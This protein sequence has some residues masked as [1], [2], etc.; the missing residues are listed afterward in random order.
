MESRTKKARPPLPE[1]GFQAILMQLDKGVSSKIIVQVIMDSNMGTPDMLKLPSKVGNKLAEAINYTFSTSD[2]LWRWL[3]ERDF[4]KLH[5][6]WG[7]KLPE[8]INNQKPQKDTPHL[9]GVPW[10]RWYYWA[11]YFERKALRIILE[12]EE[13]WLSDRQER[14]LLEYDDFGAYSGGSWDDENMN[15]SLGPKAFTC[16]FQMIPYKNFPEC[17]S[18]VYMFCGQN[19]P[20]EVRIDQIVEEGLADDKYELDSSNC[21]Y[22][23]HAWQEYEERPWPKF[24]G[25]FAAFCYLSFKQSSYSRKDVDPIVSKNPENALRKLLPAP[26]H[27]DG[28]WNVGDQV[29]ANCSADDAPGL[30]TCCEQVWYCGEECADSD[31]PKHKCIGKSLSRSKAK[32]MLHEGKTH[33]HHLTDKQ[34]RYFGWVAGGKK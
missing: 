31:W 14:G 6:E 28:R 19:T 2:E 25:Q 10:R 22:L 23:C 11:T 1:E 4:P 29:C 16:D 5:E 27:P 32:K 24:V 8:W 15:F 3:F 33:G 12:V 34:R 17:L 20:D 18:C 26:L 9:N 30:A 7:M 21:A 13:K